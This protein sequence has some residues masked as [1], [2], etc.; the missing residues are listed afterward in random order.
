MAAEP[1]LEGLDLFDADL[2]SEGPPHELFARLRAHAPVHKTPNPHGGHVWS[3]FRHDDITAVSRD[4][5]T[6]SS[7]EKGIFLQPDQVAPLDL[8]RNVLLYKDPP[9]HSRFRAVL[10]PFFTPK[11]VA[12]MEDLVHARVTKVL[13]EVAGAGRCDFV[14]DV[15]VPVA[16]GVLTELMGV[17]DDDIG[18]F[19]AWTEQIEHAQRAPEPSAG[20]DTFMEMAAYLHEQ[21]Q[22]Q[23]AGDADTLVRRLKDA[24]VDGQSLDENELLTFFALLS[25]A[26][27]DTT[28]NT[29]SAGMLDLLERPAVLARLRAHPQEIEDAVEEMLRHS[30]VVQWFAR[31]ATRDT[32]IRGQK[33]AAGDLV[34]LWYG[35]ASRDEE[36][37][38]D[39][40]A[41][42]V[43]RERARSHK[44]F[45]GGGRHACLGMHLAR[46]ELKTLFAEVLRRMPDIER[47]GPVERLGSPWANALTRLPVRFTPSGPQ[48]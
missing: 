4:A 40:D 23:L 16:L 37:F 33:I 31:T 48:H 21:V 27:N 29:A 24:E 18:R 11:S 28:R 12:G 32:E 30:S 38:A 10:Q 34:V 35:A 5:E 17:P 20:L 7:Y 26:G 45:G 14:E 39:P 46:L 15:A 36:V 47:D 41:F 9:D 2:F 22:A 19:H 13:D 3:L 42:D 6:F 25:F 1:D 44:A 43:G 8:N